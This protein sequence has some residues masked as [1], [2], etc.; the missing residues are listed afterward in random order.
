[1]SRASPWLHVSRASP[2][3]HVPGVAVATCVPGVAVATCLGRPWLRVSGAA[4]AT[5][6][7]VR[8]P[9]ERRTSFARP[10]SRRL[11]CRQS[12]DRVRNATKLHVATTPRPRRDERCRRGNGVAASAGSR[13]GSKSVS[14]NARARGSRSRIHNHIDAAYS[15]ELCARGAP[16]PPQEHRLPNASF[17]P[18]AG[19]PRRPSSCCSLRRRRAGAFARAARVL[20]RQVESPAGETYRAPRLARSGHRAAASYRAGP[21]VVGADDLE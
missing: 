15:R 16:A 6:R 10:I 20:R 14:R 9:R 21:A 2:W 12:V 18:R 7:I 5:A 17:R 13:R 11:T 19:R 1:M 3:L 4:A 8:V